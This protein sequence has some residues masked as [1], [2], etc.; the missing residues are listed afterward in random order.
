MTNIV[1]NIHIKEIHYRHLLPTF[2]TNNTPDTLAR[3]ATISITNE[4]DIVSIVI[5]FLVIFMMPKIVAHNLAH[6]KKLKLFFHVMIFNINT[7]I[8]SVLSNNEYANT[9]LYH[10]IFESFV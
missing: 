4:W 9:Q 5:Q 3:S 2:I 8:F 1:F 7:S 6:V 10:K